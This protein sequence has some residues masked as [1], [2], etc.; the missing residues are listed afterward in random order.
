MTDEL[1]PLFPFYGKISSLLSMIKY[2]FAFSWLAVRGSIQGA[3]G[4]K[5]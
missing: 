2:F 4:Q 1:L 3:A 5:D